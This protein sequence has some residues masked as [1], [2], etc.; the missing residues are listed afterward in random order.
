MTLSRGKR[1]E[2]LAK[3]LEVMLTELGDRGVNRVLFQLGSPP[4]DNILP[5]TWS[6]LEMKYLIKISRYFGGGGHFHLTSHG[7]LAAMEAS[8]QLSSDYFNRRIGALMRAMKDRV[9]ING[10]KKIGFASVE[11][12]ASTAE[13]SQGFVWNIVDSDALFVL[14]NRI[15][16]GWANNGR[17]VLIRIPVD[18]G[19][20]PL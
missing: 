6:A 2:D 1:L 10:R 7:W 19:Q 4:F 5:T 3:A 16:A 14:Q 11:A 15:G 9:D 12:I 18:F 17:G 20:E 8:G 13:V